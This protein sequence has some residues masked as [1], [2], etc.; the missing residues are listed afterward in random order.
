MSGFF[1]RLFGNRVALN[2]LGREYRLL[3]RTPVAR[4]THRFRFALDKDVELGLPTG[5]HVVVH[6]PNSTISRAYT[7][8]TSNRQRGFFDLVV[9][10]YPGGALSQYMHSLKV[11]DSA[12]ISGPSGE[13]RYLGGG[14]FEISDP[15]EEIKVRRKVWELGM[16]AGGTG[17]TPMYQIARWATEEQDPLKMRLLFANREPVDVMLKQELNDLASSSGGRLE[18]SYTVDSAD[19]Q[20]PHLQGLVSEDMLRATLGSPE[21]CGMVCVCG[22]APF[23]KVVARNLELLGFSHGDIFHF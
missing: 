7:P 9:K 3:E 23:H 10:V 21:Q 11:G 5:Q 13:I 6:L 1:A 22:P 14:E 17:I 8:T 12:T 16:V 18:V 4:A 19:A 15:F 20:W 2:S